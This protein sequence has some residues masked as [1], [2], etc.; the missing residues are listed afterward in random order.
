MDRADQRPQSLPQCWVA[1]LL[2]RQKVPG[3]V[4]KEATGFGE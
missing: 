4:S 2:D 3:G 1:G